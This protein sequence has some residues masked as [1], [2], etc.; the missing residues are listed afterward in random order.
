MIRA[1]MELPRVLAA[2]RMTAAEL[3]ELQV[4]RLRATIRHAVDQVPYYRDLFRAAAVDPDA[5]RSAEDLER[6]PVTTKADLIAAGTDAL[7][8]DVDLGTCTSKNTSGSTRKALRIPATPEER[9]EHD[10]FVFRSLLDMGLRPLDRLAV[11]S[12]VGSHRTRLYQRLGLFRSVNI[13]RFQS[14]EDQL[15]ALQRYQ[16]TFLWIYPTVMRRLLPLVVDQLSRVIRP[17]AVVHAGEV[18]DPQLRALLREDLD[19]EFF[20]LYGSTE[21]GIIAAECRAH[22]GLH[23]H[24]DR[25]LLECLG[26]DGPAPPGTRGAAVVTCLAPR[27]LPMIRYR[28]GDIFQF[29]DGPCPCGSALPL[30]GAPVGRE[31]DTLRLP[32]GRLLYPGECDAFVDCREVLRY[33]FLQDSPSR[34]R[35]QVQPRE[36]ASDDLLATLRLRVARYLGEGVH[37][38]VE[39]VDHFPGQAMKFQAF[40][41]QGS[42]AP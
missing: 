9:R 1:L 31:T 36:E 33:R 30:M 39:F 37:A 20:N 10:L 14:P 26:A 19:A 17:R 18:L 5:I 42:P 11:V 2:R 28:V 13:S 35:V 22:R 29:L 7:A 41:P 16:P 27:A 3:R 32:D 38:E 4:S 8:R 24:A 34:F 23:V 6:I 25:L 21:V 40:R 12:A 15:R